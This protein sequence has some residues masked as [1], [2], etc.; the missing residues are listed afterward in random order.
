[1]PNSKLR[2]RLDPWPADYESPTPLTGVEDDL[3]VRVDAGVEG[4]DWR[5]LP[6]GRAAVRGRIG[7]VDGVRRIEARVLADS[8]DF[9]IHGLFGS[10]AAGCVT[11]RA[12]RESGEAALFGELKVGRRL[13]LGGG[14]E[15]PDETVACGGLGLHFEGL[16]MHGNSPTDCLSQLQYLMRQT[17]ADLAETLQDACEAVF[18]DGPL[19]FFSAAKLEVVGVVKRLFAPYL[20]PKLFRLV[21]RLPP[22]CR[23]P[24]FAIAGDSHERYSWFLRIAPPG[25]LSHPLSG[26]LRLEVRAGVGLPRAVELADQSAAWLPRF[27]STPIR[28]PRAPQNLIP[29]GALER[30][31]TRRM[32]DPLII[33]R[34]IER[35]IFQELAA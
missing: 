24:L 29:T 5:A 28:D 7:F 26:V 1:M 17:E 35:T 3:A 19:T 2:L 22:A 13:I 11:A 12:A 10:F 6:A 34:A 16:S 27:A 15:A 23:T 9:V 25:P 18:I 14:A 20:E 21:P 4:C 30:E 32:G 8:E 31:L 33:R